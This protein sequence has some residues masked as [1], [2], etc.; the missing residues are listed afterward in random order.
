MASFISSSESETDL[1]SSSPIETIIGYNYPVISEENPDPQF[2]VK[3]KGM[4]YK[5]CQWRQEENLVMSNSMLLRH[6]KEKAKNYGLEE[7]PF[8]PNLYKPLSVNFDISYITPTRILASDSKGGIKKY[9]VQWGKLSITYSTWEV[10]VPDDLKKAYKNR[11]RTIM[12]P[13]KQ[14]ISFEPTNIT[15]LKFTFPNQNVLKNYQEV[16]LKWLFDKFSNGESCILADEMGMGKT[17]QTLALLQVIKHQYRIRGPFLIVVPLSVAQNWVDEIERWTTFSYLLY[18]GNQSG[19]AILKDCCFFNEKEPK[20]LKVEIVV[21]PYDNI[22][23]DIE[24]FARIYWAYC[25][26]DE[27][28]RLKNY[29]SQTYQRLSKLDY[30]ACVLLTGTPIQNSIQEVISLLHFIKPLEYPNIN[31]ITEYYE[32]ENLDKI[33]ELKE[34]LDKNILRR[35]KSESEKSIKPKEE[36]IIEVE[37]TAEQRMLYTIAV[38]D[39]KDEFMGVGPDQSISFRNISLDLRKICNH[40]YLIKNCE[41]L[42]KDQYKSR[43][44]I[45]DSQQLTPEQEMDALIE[46]SGKMILLDKL[47]PKLKAGG[48][49]VLIFSQLA[50]ILDII[51]SFLEYKGFTFERL[52]G[53]TPLNLRTQSIDNFTNNQDIF[54]FILTT[55]AGGQGINLTAADTVIIFD[56]DWN[57]QNDVQAMARCHRIGQ[58]KEVKVYRLISRHTYEE[59][60]FDRASKKLALGKILVDGNNTITLTNKEKDLMLRKGAYYI[61]KG[62]GADDSSKFCREDIDQILEGRTKTII[63]PGETTRVAKVTFDANQ[64]SV[65][66]STADTDHVSDSGADTEQEHVDFEAADFWSQFFQPETSTPRARRRINLSENFDKVMK[67]KEYRII[68]GLIRAEGL[69]ATIAKERGS[70]R[71]YNFK[72]AAI[73][74]TLWKN[75]DFRTQREIGYSTILKYIPVS[76]ELNNSLLDCR[77]F[78]DQAFIYK[79]F[80]EDTAS[81]VRNSF[82][83]DYLFRLKTYASS[84]L[85]TN[86]CLGRSCETEFWWSSIHDYVL[87]QKFGLDFSDF[88]NIINAITPKIAIC[89]SYS[90]PLEKCQERQNIIFHE[91]EASMPE[92]FISLVPPVSFYNFNTMHPSDIEVIRNS[93]LK[94]IIKA[95]FMIQFKEI[96]DAAI[97]VQQ[98][99]QLPIRVEVISKY[100]KGILKLAGLYNYECTPI[101]PRELKFI[102]HS[103]L[104]MLREQILFNKKIIT[105]AQ[106]IQIY[107]IPKILPDSIKSIVPSWWKIEH[108]DCLLIQTAKTG[109]SSLSSLYALQ[110]FQYFFRLPRTETIDPYMQAEIEQM[111]PLLPATASELFFLANITNWKA[112]IKATIEMYSTMS[113]NQEIV[114]RGNYPLRVISIGKMN[115]SGVPIGYK[116]MRFVTNIGVELSILDGPIFEARVGSSVIRNKD[117]NAVF[118]AVCSEI[119]PAIVG[120]DSFTFDAYG[121]FGLRTPAIRLLITEN[122]R[123]N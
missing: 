22:I 53:S 84:L 60:M 26:F 80:G 75:L 18:T 25:I 93:Q 39:H 57:P 71:L 86:F 46:T 13:T 87:I 58:T 55:K 118:T 111:L 89:S 85:A 52:D 119:P 95:L 31:E 104:E 42:V 109:F 77:P 98:F 9:L 14:E 36:T 96:S 105:V 121:F 64:E 10:S 24:F 43:K 99:A 65:S 82:E 59:E 49:K 116:I 107:K 117:I 66:D 88:N 62:I 123:K 8:I 41:S 69:L 15:N 106:A 20:K 83:K 3:L 94:R 21:V 112:I 72:C 6:F 48:H 63:A 90:V 38:D 78:N 19:R 120:N 110:P 12:I 32:G 47:L 35:T 115:A 97:A 7:V 50:I 61:L 37:L 103:V 108:C 1:N 79:L 113:V 11:I 51:Q 56:S 44:G 100:I 91:L 67:K 27:A 29:Q 16:G 68:Q 45:P 76:Q 28:H 70:D 34:V 74:Y 33:S 2:Y 17:I 81:F 54:V 4:S 40:P 92:N 73:I 122:N 30:F 5:D 101:P 23:D 114:R 102:P